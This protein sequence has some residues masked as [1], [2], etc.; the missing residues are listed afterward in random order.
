M[1]YASIFGV[2]TGFAGAAYDGRASIHQFTQ[3]NGPEPAEYIF[4]AFLVPRTDLII[5]LIERGFGTA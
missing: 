1:A 5:F 2:S 3:Y 4:Y